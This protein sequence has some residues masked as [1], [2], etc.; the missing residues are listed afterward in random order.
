MP[1]LK[2]ALIIDDDSDIRELLRMMLE[3]GGF[4]VDALSDGIDAVA[5]E[6]SY[7]VILLDLQMPVFDGRRLTDYW[8]LTKPEILR[9]VIV[10][11]GYSRLASDR[12]PATFASVAK[13]FDYRELMKVVDA[14]AA[15][16]GKAPSS[17]GDHV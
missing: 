9:R 16:F 4:Q 7:D 10:L 13:P 17:G 12:R 11:T 5:I 15:Q 8:E 1:D 14:C 6:K 3:S 2:T